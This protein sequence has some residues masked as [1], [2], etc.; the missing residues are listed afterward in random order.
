MLLR[1]TSTSTAIPSH[2]FTEPIDGI[3]QIL[4]RGLAVEQGPAAWPEERRRVDGAVL[5]DHAPVEAV[6][7][8]TS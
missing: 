4:A 2:G 5:S 7:A 8:S 3:D 6:I 1:A